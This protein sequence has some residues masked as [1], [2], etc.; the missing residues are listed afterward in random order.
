MPDVEKP[1][2]ESTEKVKLKPIKLAELQKGNAFTH[3]QPETE[4]IIHFC[5][6]L[7]SEA[8]YKFKQT[9]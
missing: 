7:C 3:S 2:I 4:F 1:K 8:E 5:F 9:K 6:R